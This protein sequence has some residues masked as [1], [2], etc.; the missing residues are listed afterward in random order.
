MKIFWSWQ[1]DLPGK[2]N[3]HFVRGALET[4]IDQLKQLQEIDEPY[5]RDADNELHLDHDRK[6]VP[7]SPN[8]ADTIFEKIALSHVFIADV[9]PVSK[10][11]RQNEK[12]KKY[13]KKIMNPNVAIEVGYALNAITDERVLMV[14]NSH[15]GTREDLPFDLAHKAGPISFNLPPNASNADI[16]TALKSLVSALKVALAPY[17]SMSLKVSSSDFKERN[18]DPETRLFFKTTATLMS[19]GDER[20]GDKINYR[21]PTDRFFYLRMIPTT[22][23]PMPFRK[24]DLAKRATDC[25]LPP[26]CRT[27]DWS[28]RAN[29][30]GAIV[31]SLANNRTDL[32][33]SL[34]QVFDTG[35][36]WGANRNLFAEPKSRRFIP[37]GA[38][39]ETLKITLKAYSSFLDEKLDLPP[40]YTL[41]FGARGLEACGLAVK[42]SWGGE[43]WDLLNNE[44]ACRIVLQS[45]NDE[46]LESAREHFLDELYNLTGHNRPKQG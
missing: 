1:S 7:G 4:A 10:V 18:S 43:F 31:P 20:D 29:G 36:I 41:E 15:F 46:D 39:D 12:G 38:L 22:R 26:F 32:L 40:P 34:T 24:I 25:M 27:R 2:T 23:A 13:F 19:L 14:F 35:E 8:L 37:T 3:R 28:A 17:L 11:E 30:F 44:L 21:F 33:D 6:G 9:T 42:G 5:E 45:R 16:K